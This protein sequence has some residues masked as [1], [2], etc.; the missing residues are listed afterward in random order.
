MKFNNI[1]Q[2]KAHQWIGNAYNDQPAMN[3][4]D[5]FAQDTNN[6]LADRAEALRQ[7]SDACMG[8]GRDEHLTDEQVVTLYLECCC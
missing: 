1:E 4:I 3:A 5:V 2:I 6:A 8:C 7:L